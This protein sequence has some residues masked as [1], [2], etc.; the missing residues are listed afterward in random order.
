M[1]GPRTRS[2]TTATCSKPA[3]R[4][5]RGAPP[6]CSPI[7][8]WWRPILALPAPERTVPA[9]L[10]RAA[11]RHGDR[12]LVKIAGGEWHHRDALEIVARRAGALRAAGIERG[13]RVALMCSH[14]VELLEVF[15]A[16]GSR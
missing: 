12:P 15:L 6:S 5:S 13:D 4:C 11:E 1:R 14:R 7:L 2:T 8:G 10:R 9:M 16:C 3:R